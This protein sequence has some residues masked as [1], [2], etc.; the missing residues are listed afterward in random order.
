M[1]LTLLDPA[2][3][4][5]FENIVANVKVDASERLGRCG[6]PRS[7]LRLIDG[8]FKAPT[9]GLRKEILCS[10]SERPPRLRGDRLRLVPNLEV[11]RDR[12][13][14]DVDTEYDPDR[15]GFNG[16]F[17][18]ARPR[19]EEVEDDPELPS[20][21]RAAKRRFCVRGIFADFRRHDLGPNFWERSFDG[22]L[23][24]ELMTEPL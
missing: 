16:L 24:R 10:R 5:S 15:G 4:G 7:I 21:R 18:T 22:T 19:Y 13:V 12:R 17:A 3:P 2:L 14:A 8:L 20:V 1:S 6:R 11:A 23:Q 9:I